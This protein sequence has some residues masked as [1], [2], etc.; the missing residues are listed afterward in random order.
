ME[1]YGHVVAS[2]LH[3]ELDVADAELHRR[4]ERRQRVLRKVRGIAAMGDDFGQGMARM[5][6]SPRR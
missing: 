1:H 3:V 2:Q 6:R 5:H 4:L